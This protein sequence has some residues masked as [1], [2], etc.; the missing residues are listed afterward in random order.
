MVM[1]IIKEDSK[2]GPA[3]C[4]KCGADAKINDGGKWYCGMESE[5]GVFNIRGYC[6]K[7][8]KKKLESN[9]N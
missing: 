5:M 1:V 3:V 2:L 8:R 4:C 9:N 6:I 7:E